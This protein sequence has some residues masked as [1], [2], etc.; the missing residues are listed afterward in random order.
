MNFSSFTLVFGRLRDHFQ[1][2]ILSPSA[3]DTITT[4]SIGL[5]CSQPS[6]TSKSVHV[7][8]SKLM[9]AYQ[10]YI[11]NERGRA[12][13]VSEEE[14]NGNKKEDPVVKQVKQDPGLSMHEKGLLSCI[15]DSRECL[16][17]C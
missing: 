5:S 3:A 1:S 10:M 12:D 4:T 7:T 11:K 17:Y 8:P 13:W 15:V 16:I 14:K 9:E 2:S 6:N